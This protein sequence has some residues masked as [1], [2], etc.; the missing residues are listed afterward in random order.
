MQEI[1]S[2]TRKESYTATG[3]ADNETNA[4]PHVL[5]IQEKFFSRLA[6]ELRVGAPGWLI[7]L[8]ICLYHSMNA[9][10]TIMRP[11]VPDSEYRE[12]SDRFQGSTLWIIGADAGSNS[13][14]TRAS[15]V[16]LNDWYG[17]TAAHVI[18]GK[19]LLNGR[20][21]VVGTGNSAGT[22]R[23]EIRYIT[24]VLLHPNRKITDGGDANQASDNEDLAIIQFDHPL[25][26]PD[27][28]IVP[29]ARGEI[30]TAGAFGV[31]GRPFD[32]GTGQDML[33]RSFD[34]EVYPNL[35][36]PLY[37]SLDFYPI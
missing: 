19:G 27:R 13:G 17:L 18:A 22:N 36:Y 11:G 33:R 3:A 5:P 20:Q 4:L 35:I 14:A 29:E 21:W 6:R 26:G 28:K 25:P 1:Q 9:H 34:A 23:G 2:P 15:A 24:R 32:C 16:R 7:L 30:V 8:F 37:F 31:P 10:G 12:N